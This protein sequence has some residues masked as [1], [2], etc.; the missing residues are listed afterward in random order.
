[1]VS[2][3]RR[4]Q[5]LTGVA[6]AIYSVTLL[7]TAYAG[8]IPAALDY[9]ETV[10]SGTS[11]SFLHNPIESGFFGPSSDAFID[12]IRFKG[13]P[14][15]LRG[16][17]GTTDALVRR[18]NDVFIAQNGIN[19]PQQTISIQIADLNLVSI[20][21][22][23]V[24]YNQGQNSELWDVN[25][26]LSPNEEQST[27]SMTIVIQTNAVGG[28]YDI[29]LPVRMV[30]LFT[31]RSDN[32]TLGLPMSVEFGNNDVP[33][34]RNAPGRV[35]QTAPNFCPTCIDGESRVSTL[36]APGD[37]QWQVQVP[38]TEFLLK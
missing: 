17:L 12:T 14:I 25:V 4:I 35:L 24:T 34:S 19:S 10:P 30:V 31:R 23:T 22:I 27:G 29:R 3:Y 20:S 15:N 9:Y 37:I 26:V 21:P 13:V 32:A 2:I 11:I 36:T 38:T 16:P 6:G 33:W 18:L 1:M 5:R 7:I 8:Q 28:T